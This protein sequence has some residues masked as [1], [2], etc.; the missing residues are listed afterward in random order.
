MQWLGYSIDN[1]T[2]LWGPTPS[3]DS[4]NFYA[5]TTGAFGVGASAVAYGHLYSTGYSGIVYCYDLKNGSLL[6]NYS[7]PAGLATPYG[8]YSLLMGAVADGKIYLYSYEHSANAPHWVGSKTR[9]IDA[10]TGKEIW[11]IAGWAAYNSMFVADSYMVS[12]NLYDMQIYCFGKGPS[13]TTVTAPDTAVP[14]GSSVVI[15]GTVT[16]QTPS[17]KAKGTPAIS[18]ASMGQW[19]EYL[20]MQKPIPTNATGVEVTLD[21]IDPN[22]NFVHIG[23]VKSD[24]SGAFGYMWEP[25]VP[26]TYTV[27]ATFAGSESY[28]SSYAQTYVGV[29]EAPAAPAAPEPAAPLPPFEMYTLYATIAIIVAIAIVGLMLMRML[30]KR[31]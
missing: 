26:G 20:Y 1:G 16:D 7:A 4:W 31:P 28:W 27:I 2:L 17:S 5:L 14:L 25:E 30:R 9:C 3:E 6:W 29:S 15:R 21:T 11:T 24:T 12:L 23:T 22:N 10:N 8:R 13:A 19:M 18:D